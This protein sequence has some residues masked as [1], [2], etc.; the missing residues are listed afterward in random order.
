MY[1]FK[2]YGK[3]SFNL[4]MTGSDLSTRRKALQGFRFPESLVDVSPVLHF[5]LVREKIQSAFST[6]MDPFFLKDKRISQDRNT[7]T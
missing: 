7:K 3:C 6:A 1:S 2:T 5:F 4:G